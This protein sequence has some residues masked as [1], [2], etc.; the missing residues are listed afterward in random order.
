MTIYDYIAYK[1]PLG[2]KQV[3]NSYGALANRRPD[4]LAKQ[5]ANTVNKHGKQALYKI[6]GVHPDLELITHFNDYNSEQEKG[7]DKSCSCNE[8]AFSSLEGQAIKEAVQD[9]QVKQKVSEQT[10]ETKEKTESKDLLI[11]GAIA[12]I[13][14]ALIM[15]K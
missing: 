15:R 5:L 13:S 11:I 1:N 6:A 4:I 3:I 8:S 12:V 2:A 7:K 14:L 10:P 9:L